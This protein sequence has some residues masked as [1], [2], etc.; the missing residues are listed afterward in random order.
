M[1][2]AP[3]VERIANLSLHVLDALPHH[4]VTSAPLNKVR[5]ALDY[6]PVELLLALQV[7]SLQERLALLHQ[8]HVHLG[9]V[10]FVHPVVKLQ[11]SS[12]PITTHHF[13]PLKN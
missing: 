3:K 6:R 8:A 10:P 9:R 7:V 13:L 1:M 2:V 12:R 4:Y 11:T 5:F